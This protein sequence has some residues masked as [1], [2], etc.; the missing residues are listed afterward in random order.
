MLR[1]LAVDELGLRL[2]GLATDAVEPLVRVLVDVPVVVDALEEVLDERLVALVGGADEEVGVG[3]DA[4]RKRAPVLD[5]LVG[6]LLRRE[7]LLLG[8]ARDLGG[9]LVGAREEERL[10]AALLVMAHQNVRRDGRVRMTDV[11]RRV[12]VVDGCR[13]VEAHLDQ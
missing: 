9:V 8:D 4:L 5:D 13:Q 12:D 10:V 3:I 2:E 1:A 7:A 11:R 6:V